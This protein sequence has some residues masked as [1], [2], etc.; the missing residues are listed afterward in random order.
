MESSDKRKREEEEEVPSELTTVFAT[1][2]HRDEDK[3]REQ[4]QDPE[5]RG[6]QKSSIC[7]L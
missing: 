2:I 1:M 6:F 7:D 4:T 5:N 3:Q